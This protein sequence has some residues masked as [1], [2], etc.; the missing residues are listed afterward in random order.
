V[1]DD[2]ETNDGPPTMD[3]PT[4]PTP[5]RKTAEVKIE[6]RRAAVAWVVR[7]RG[8]DVRITVEALGES[9][10]A[11]TER[12]GA[13]ATAVQSALKAKASGASGVARTALMALVPPQAAAAARVA[14]VVGRIARAGKL[15]RAIGRLRGPALAL[16]RR[17]T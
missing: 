13:I 14:L 12:A 1:E 11:A 16:A 5:T 10:P 17:L 15:G 8:G 3:E 6:A 9:N 7:S 4:T 2:S